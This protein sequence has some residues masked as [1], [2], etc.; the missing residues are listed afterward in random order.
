MYLYKQY[1]EAILNKLQK[2]YTFAK[3]IVKSKKIKLKKADIIRIDNCDKKL[4]KDDIFE[5]ILIKL[6]KKFLKYHKKQKVDMNLYYYTLIHLMKNN[7]EHV[8]IHVITYIKQI[9]SELCHNVNIAHF[10]KC[11]KNTNLG[12]IL[13]SFIPQFYD[14]QIPPP[15]ILVNNL[16]NEKTLIEEALSI[17]C[18]KKVKIIKPIKGENKKALNI[19][20]KNAKISIAKRLSEYN[21]QN[22]LIKTLSKKLKLNFIP[23]RIEIFDNSHFSG[24][25]M[26][27]VMVVASQKGFLKSEYRKYNIKNNT[28]YFN[29]A[30]DYG[31]MNEVFHRRFKKFNEINNNLNKPDLIIVDGGKGQCNIACKVLSKLNIKNII[32]IGIAKGKNRNSGNEK[33]YFPSFK[34]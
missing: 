33:I 8:N 14:K 25:N 5:F 10:I 28:E 9:M 26:L 23:K 2:K 20:I 18:E 13:K 24:S 16:P 7:I 19:S 34:E 11:E 3:Y 29:P 6:L 21:T 17:K 22:K 4:N 15:I 12:E 27:G 32:V 31:M 30:N 1:W